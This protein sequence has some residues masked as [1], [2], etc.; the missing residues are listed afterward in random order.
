MND[1]EKMIRDLKEAR[2]ELDRIIKDT[3][4]ELGQ[5]PEVFRKELQTELDSVI[6]KFYGGYRPKY[7]KRHKK[8]E[9][10]YK[11]YKIEQD[12]FDFDVSYSPENLPD[13]YNQDREII[14]NNVFA[15]GF[16]GGSGGTDWMKI[17]IPKNKPRWRT[18]QPYYDEENDIDVGGYYRWYKKTAKKSKSPLKQIE[19]IKEEK[20]SAFNK[21]F[22]EFCENAV[23]DAY[24]VVEKAIRR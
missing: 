16:H 9:G 15:N 1:I 10:L 6:T 11:A 20:I 5:K 3:K 24:N 13:D 18:P 12:G 21:E 7:Y 22:Q 8:G 19:K 4:K 2:K 17:K 14:Y 23:N